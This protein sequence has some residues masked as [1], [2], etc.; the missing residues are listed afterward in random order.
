VHF[1]NYFRTLNVYQVISWIVWILL[2]AFVVL[3]VKSDENLKNSL[4][5]KNI[6]LIFGFAGGLFMLA[7]GINYYLEIAKVAGS[8]NDIYIE[9]SNLFFYVA[10]AYLAYS[11]IVG[12]FRF[13]RNK[14]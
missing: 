2:I 7:M 11:S 3:K 5:A 12:Y 8:D 4:S 14:K 6:L 9:Y 13:V 1:F 10:A